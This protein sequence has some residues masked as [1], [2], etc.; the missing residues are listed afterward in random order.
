[1]RSC[2]SS[3][4]THY[5][6]EYRTH[7]RFQQTFICGLLL[8]LHLHQQKTLEAGVCLPSHLHQSYHC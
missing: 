7:C 8:Q 5:I 3:D 6:L 2:T 4:E 1:M